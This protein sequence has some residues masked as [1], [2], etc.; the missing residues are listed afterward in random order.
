MQCRLVA[1]A[2]AVAG[3]LGLGVETVGASRVW[4]FA[5]AT[6]SRGTG[7]TVA[8][9]SHG[10]PCALRVGIGEGTL[11]RRV[12]EAWLAVE[13]GDAAKAFPCSNDLGPNALLG[14]SD[15]NYRLERRD[16]RDNE[17]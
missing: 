17:T 7:V 6:A 15:G 14:L 11:G 9:H 4:P 12:A 5:A 3:A 8:E 16:I 13:I 1:A 10:V 2:V